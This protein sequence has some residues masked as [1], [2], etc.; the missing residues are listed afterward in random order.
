MTTM[1]STFIAA[2]MS[3]FLIPASTYAQEEGGEDTTETLTI[4]F[5][6][7]KNLVS[8]S[9]L[10]EDTSF[11]GVFG[12]FYGNKLKSIVTEGQIALRLDAGPDE[13]AWIGS[14]DSFG[15]AK[16]YWVDIFLTIEDVSPFD[17][18]IV[19]EATQESVVIPMHTGD[20]WAAYPW[21]VDV[22]VEGAL[23]IYI[24]AFDAVKGETDIH[25][26][27]ITDGVPD[28][29]DLSMNSGRGY[30]LTANQDVPDFQFYE[31]EECNG[32]TTYAYG[33]TD[34][35]AVNTDPDADFDDGSCVYDVPAGWTNGYVSSQA[36]Y[37]FDNVYVSC[38]P[39]AGEDSI[40]AFV[41]GENV[42]YGF[43]D[44][45][46]FV[47]VPAFNAEEGSAV[48]FKIH[49]A[50]LG[51]T[52]ELLTADPVTYTAFNPSEN[53][54]WAMNQITIYGCMEESAKNTSL[55]A[56]AAINNCA[57]IV[58]QTTSCA[59]IGAECGFIDNGCGDMIPC[60][61]CDDPQV[62][63]GGGVENI[64][65]CTALECADN[66]CGEHDDGCGGTLDCDG[67]EEGFDCAEDGWCVSNC[68]PLTCESANAE[69]G[70]LDD[71]CGGVLN[72]DALEGEDPA[73][74]DEESCIDNQCVCEPW[75]SCDDLG[76]TCGTIDDGCGNTL[77]CGECEEGQTCTEAQQ[78]E[79][80]E[81]ETGEEETGEEE[82]G[83]EETGEEE[84]GEEE[85]GA[86]ETGE[87]ETGEEE[88][89]EEETG[90]E[91]TGAEETG[92][93]ETGAEETGEDTGDA[94]GG[95]SSGGGGGCQTTSPAPGA[96][97]FALLGLLAIVGRRRR[98]DARI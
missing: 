59:D 74:G 29:G 66:Q 93:E 16:A 55:I 44:S 19:G 56:E 52:V 81:E 71:G 70:E 88:T 22:P 42:G 58:Q 28:K 69:C 37:V 8:F 18:S 77:E 27:T 97:G 24:A 95:G 17:L 98:R 31:C 4:E 94:T 82:T 2:I 92:E 85:T 40:G 3:L 64:C 63:G 83:E 54:L 5:H 86:E 50:D 72:C 48:T 9:V 26:T 57:P 80:G 91:E 89:G 67:C 53:Q 78:C 6:S 7:N 20:N 25:T 75:Q 84:T 21:T 36:F 46:G 43:P 61:T 10:P 15:R 12:T 73:C 41:D 38:S 33:C 13:G 47:T 76:Y 1:K 68:A 39:L 49:D 90:E 62:C 87:E 23:G 79:T 65:G 96:L 14:L 34:P 30:I 60:G 51:K 11:E 45:L 32:V 35:H